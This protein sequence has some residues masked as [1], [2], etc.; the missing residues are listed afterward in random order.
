MIVI[1]SSQSTTLYSLDT[2]GPRRPPPFVVCKRPDAYKSEQKNYISGEKRESPLVS[3]L[4]KIKPCQH[5][6]LSACINPL[7][8]RSPHPS[9]PDA[10]TT[11]NS[12]TI[13]STRFPLIRL[14]GFRLVEVQHRGGSDEDEGNGRHVAGGAGVGNVLVV[15]IL[16]GR[17]SARA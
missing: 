6:G 13:I 11:S 1:E 7:I 17:R 3:R 16:R 9:K 8:I 10:G 2:I 12:K 4:R 15:L 5:L 14:V